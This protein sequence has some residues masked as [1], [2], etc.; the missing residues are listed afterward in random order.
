M[1]GPNKNYWEKGRCLVKDL[2]FTQYL[3]LVLRYNVL[4]LGNRYLNASF[5]VNK[6]LKSHSGGLMLLS[7]IGGAIAQGITKQ[8]LNTRSS[9]EAEVVSADEF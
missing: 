9:T 4:S 3:H 2:K 7:K 6:N 1:R 5:R 8:K